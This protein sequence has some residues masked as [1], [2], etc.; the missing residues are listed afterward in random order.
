MILKEGEILL[1][2]G[3]DAYLWTIWREFVKLPPVKKVK[4]FY[5]LTLEEMQSYD[6]FQSMILQYKKP[7]TILLPYVS[8]IQEY[9]KD[10]GISLPTTTLFDVL[11]VDFPLFNVDA[12]IEFVD[13][14]KN[15]Q[16]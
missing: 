9:V 3:I 2:F 13:K 11:V 16:V 5:H 10:K 4:N 8:E 14:K 15:T 12:F 6:S 7:D 1:G